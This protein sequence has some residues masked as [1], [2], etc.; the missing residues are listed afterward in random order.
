MN[1]ETGQIRVDRDGNTVYVVG[2]VIRQAEGRKADTVEVAVPGQPRGLDAGMRVEVRDLM[3]VQWQMG[4]RSGTSFR[5]AAITPA[6]G[7]GPSVSAP[8][9]PAAGR[10]KAGP[11]GEG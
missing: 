10:S 5:A 11:G 9:A 4:D 6:P 8:A 3:A 2:L 1:P 7:S